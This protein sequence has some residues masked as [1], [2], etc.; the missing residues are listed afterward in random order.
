MAPFVVYL[1]VPEDA[2]RDECAGVGVG[3]TAAENLLLRESDA[4][5]RLHVS[6]MKFLEKALDAH[7]V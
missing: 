3:R 7:Y 2:D 5:V 4:R 6:P 1:L